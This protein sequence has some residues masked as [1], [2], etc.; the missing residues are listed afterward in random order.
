MYD[1]LIVGC[2]LFGSVFAR[3][4][5]NI[6]KTCLI[7]DK[8]NH[9]GGN[10][11][12][13]K[14]DNIDFH[15]YGPH[16]FHTDK[17]E[18]WDYINKYTKFNNYINKPKVFYKNEIYSFPINLFTLY[19]IYGVKTPLEAKKVLETEKIKIKNP[20]NFEE[21]ALSS[22]G[23]KLYE[24]FIKGY[25]RKQWGK[26]PKDLPSFIFNRLPIRTKYDDNYYYDKYQGIPLEG[27][28]KLFE[29]LLRGIEI[30]LNTNYFENRDFFD[31]IS[32]KIIFTGKIDEFFNYEFGELE[33][34]TLEFES[35][36]LETE[37][38]QGNSIINYTDYSI[39]YTRVLEHK[40]FNWKENINHTWITKEFSTKYDKNKGIPYY[41][42]SINE[43]NNIY[44]L[45]IEKS[46]NKN[47][48]FCGRLGEYKYYNMDDIIRSSLELIKK[49][50]NYENR[51]CYNIIG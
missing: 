42:V 1:Y 2:G 46:K 17:K 18:I 15:L 32:N 26:D 5:S 11:Y 6:G 35:E 4:M 49:E 31:K 51:L 8:R 44:K 34:R 10:C 38:Y 19:Q 20:S 45:Y 3:E 14:R 21:M 40:H 36:I 48:I 9:I 50:L 39:P 30:R 29:N 7:I 28:D 13:E 25:T 27:Y 23:E 37:D 12:S 43:N 22:I 33:Y 16:I 47:I 41:P 24:M